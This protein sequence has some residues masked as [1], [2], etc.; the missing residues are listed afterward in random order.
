MEDKTLM[1]SQTDSTLEEPYRSLKH[2]FQLLQAEVAELRA[3]EARLNQELEKG[4]A[5]IQAGRTKNAG[6]VFADIRRD[7]GL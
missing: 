3:R 5:D 1:N 7:Y 6:R 2:D 4:Y